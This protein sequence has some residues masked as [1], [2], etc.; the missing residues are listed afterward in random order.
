MMKVLGLA[1]GIVVGYEGRI[2]LFVMPG[3]SVIARFLGA[4]S[5]MRSA[6]VREFFEESDPW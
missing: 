2:R 1:T 5:A 3:T 6:S 4:P